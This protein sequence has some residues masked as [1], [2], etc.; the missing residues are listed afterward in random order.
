MA[1][2]LAPPSPRFREQLRLTYPR[3]S[4]VADASAVERDD[5]IH[6]PDATPEDVVTPAPR[7][8]DGLRRP[9]PGLFDRWPEGWWRGSV[10]PGRTASKWVDRETTHAPFDARMF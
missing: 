2:G 4:A 6:A 8:R 5:F 3:L 7:T 9:Q 10:V 1:G